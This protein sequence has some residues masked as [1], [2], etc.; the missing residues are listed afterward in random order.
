MATTK[1]SN[2]PSQWILIPWKN[3]GNFRKSKLLFLLTVLLHQ[4]A[5]DTWTEQILFGMFV[6]WHV[7]ILE[8][9]LQTQELL[10]LH[11][12]HSAA[13]AVGS[14]E[15]VAAGPSLDS[16]WWFSAN[17]SKSQTKPRLLRFF[18]VKGF[19]DG[20]FQ[21]TIFQKLLNHIWCWPETKCRCNCLGCGPLTWACYVG[22]I[23]ALAVLWPQGG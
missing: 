13:A 9:G 15:T 16:T 21:T 1:L 4:T 22:F 20:G 10:H 2:S 12:S 11:L 5:Q 23:Q 6:D 17:Q 3:N 14:R 7:S 19:G 8:R 18:T